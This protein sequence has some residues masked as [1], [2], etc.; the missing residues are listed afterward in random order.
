MTNRV[1]LAAAA[2]ALYSTPS[3]SQD[4]VATVA[5]RGDTPRTKMEEVLLGHGFLLKREIRYAGSVVGFSASTEVAAA[6]FSRMGSSGEV[7]AMRGLRIQVN[8]GD[9]GGGSRTSFVDEEEIPSLMA[10]WDLLL[11]RAR[12]TKDSTLVAYTEHEYESVGG[13]GIG[14]YQKGRSQSWWIESRGVVTKST[15]FPSAG[16]MTRLRTA[17]DSAAK[18]LR[19]W[20]D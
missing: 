20:K 5:S 11:E 14:F 4:T 17:V 7:R 6:I 3:Y 13:L 8:G 10:A 16:N 12:S 2:I 9:G 15:Y 1:L 19:D 18:L